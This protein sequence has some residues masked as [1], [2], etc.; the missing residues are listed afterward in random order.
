MEDKR[1]AF[2]IGASITGEKVPGNA[3]IPRQPL[4]KSSKNPLDGVLKDYNLM[5]DFS[6]PVYE[7]MLG[8][9]H[10]KL[11]KSDILGAFKNFFGQK[12]TRR[13]VIYYSGHGSNGTFN[14]NKGDWCFETNDGSETRIVYVGLKDLLS[15]GMR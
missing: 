1:S 4:D 2:L 6:I 10:A 3:A 15:C 14:T 11:N 8:N 12:G 13:F 9:H 7:V 5:K